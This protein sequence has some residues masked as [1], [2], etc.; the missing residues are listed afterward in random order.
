MLSKALEDL[1]GNIRKAVNQVAEMMTGGLVIYSMRQQDLQE[2]IYAQTVIQLDGD[3][4]TAYSRE[5]IESTDFEALTAQHMEEVEATLKPLAS[6]PNYI[7]RAQGGLVSIGAFGG[8]ISTVGSFPSKNLSGFIGLL[9][10]ALFVASGLL[11]RRI[12][13]K[14]AEHQVKRLTNVA[15]REAEAHAREV[16]AKSL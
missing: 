15:K 3:V 8:L 1:V 12:V 7:G 16:L 6:L 10:S 14:I 5:V 9:G 4:V 2:E 13:R 11:V